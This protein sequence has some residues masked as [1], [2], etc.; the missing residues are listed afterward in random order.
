MAL[1]VFTDFLVAVGLRRKRVRKLVSREAALAG[2]VE[3]RRLLDGLGMRCWLTDGTLLGFYREGDFLG[4]DKDIDLGCLIEEYKD[5]LVPA[6]AAAGWRLSHV[7][8]RRDCGLELS[9]EK[10]GIKVDLFF[11]YREDGGLWHAA[12]R[13]VDKKTRNMIRYGYDAFGLREDTFLGEKFLVPDDTL[14]YVATKYG[15]GWRTPVKDWDWAF[16]P[17]NARATDVRM[18]EGDVRD[19]KRAIG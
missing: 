8:G 15:E 1:G 18:R 3:A 19:P 17:A 7:F 2:L 6:F 4:H 14:K 10:Q 5:G 9:F 13:R 12:W 16:G 11:F